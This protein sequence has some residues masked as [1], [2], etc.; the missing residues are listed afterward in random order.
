VPCR[1][2]REAAYLDFECLH[3]E[4]IFATNIPSQVWEEAIAHL[5][6]F[7]VYM[8]QYRNFHGSG[9]AEN[10]ARAMRFEDD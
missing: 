5:L 2:H 7:L 9:T 4:Y 10:P 3:F 8:A 1:Q 6:D